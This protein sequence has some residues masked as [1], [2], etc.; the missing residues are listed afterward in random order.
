VEFCAMKHRKKQSIKSQDELEYI[1]ID[2]DNYITIE[3]IKDEYAKENQIL[4][5]DQAEKIKYVLEQI[6]EFSFIRFQQHQQEKQKCK[7]IELK[8]NEEESHFIHTSK[9]RR[10]S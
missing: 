7:I 3:Q 2:V 4:T 8:T 9:Y 10:A 1:P 6:M 5:D